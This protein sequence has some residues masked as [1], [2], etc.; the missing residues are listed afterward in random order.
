MFSLMRNKAHTMN[1]Y[2]LTRTNLVDYDQY[3][4]AVVAAES[5][6]A[7]RFTFP[8]KNLLVAWNEEKSAWIS[9][10]KGGFPQDHSWTWQPPTDIRVE[11]IGVSNSTTPG[12]I[13]S[14]DYCIP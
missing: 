12:V 10:T 5:E 14:S 11:L 8:D 6:S 1:L 9:K 2:L 3:D 7:A 13:M 4:A